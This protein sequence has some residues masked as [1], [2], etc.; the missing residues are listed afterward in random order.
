MSKV[1]VVVPTIREECIKAFLEAWHPHLEGCTIL[2]IEDNPE[3]SFQVKG[4]NVLHFAWAEI[5][6]DLGEK[7]WIV[8]RRTDCIRSYGF[9]K[10]WHLGA[11]VIISLDDDCYPACAG[12]VQSHLQKLCS[13]HVS[14]AWCSTLK[15]ILPRGMPY[16][17][18]TREGKVV[19]NHGLWVGIPDYD[20]VTQLALTRFSAPHEIHEQV[21][22]RGLF[23]PMCGMNIAFRR[24]LTPAMYFL[25][26]GRDWPFDRFGDIWCGIL[27]KRICDH[28]GYI[29]TSGHPLVEHKRAS[30]VWANLRKE[31]AG[32]EANEEFWV[33]IDNA[34]LT[35]DSVTGCY[36]QLA[37]LLKRRGGYWEKLGE[38]MLLWLSLFE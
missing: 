36:A 8:P 13:M 5:D 6:R 24:E 12:F 23:F 22:P 9:L 20:A 37:G 25:L 34:I 7:A 3:R 2:I 14:D 31:V 19:L 33:V 26:M 32:Y 35:S 10:A 4:S 1:V 11:D 21:I 30:N 29:V 38:A 15:G 16:L 17:K 28:L 18:R 27:A